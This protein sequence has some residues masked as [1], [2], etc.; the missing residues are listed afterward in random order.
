MSFHLSIPQA[1]ND[2]FRAN[3]VSHVRV[4][5]DGVTKPCPLF[6]II[7]VGNDFFNIDQA[8]ERGLLKLPSDFTRFGELTDRLSALDVNYLIELRH[9]RI[10]LVKFIEPATEGRS[11]D[12]YLPEMLAAQLLRPTYEVMLNHG[13]YNVMPHWV[14][15]EVLHFGRGMHGEDRWWIKYIDSPGSATYAR[16]VEEAEN[17]LRAAVKRMKDEG[18]NCMRTDFIPPDG[19]ELFETA[20]SEMGDKIELSIRGYDATA[21]I[22]LKD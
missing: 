21:S 2:A 19:M 8:M 16:L 20:V 11:I 22:T 3:R 15:H 9:G 13:V 17:R 12:Y 5:D 7:R 1:V 4:V 10:P 14:K 18:H 6:R